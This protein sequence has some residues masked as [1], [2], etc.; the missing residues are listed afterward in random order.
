MV[1][2]AFLSQA[3]ADAT[4]GPSTAAARLSLWGD[5]ALSDPIFLLVLP[6]LGLAFWWGRSRAGRPRARV[7]V[8]AEGLPVSLRQRLG[9]LPTT[10]AFCASV[11]AVLAMAR[12][13]RANALRT[14]ISEGVDI[15]VVVDR[16]GSMQHKDMAAGRTRLDVV[17]DV[18]ADFVARRTGDTAGAADK[19]ALL[20][21][22]R[23]PELLCPF[24]LDADAI[25]GF[26][27]NVQLANSAAEG[28]T[29]IGSALAK[30]VA[31]LTDSEAKSRIVVLLTDGENT[32]FD[33]QPMEAAELAAE[34]GIKVYTIFA[35]KY[36]YEYDPFRGWRAT[37]REPDTREL[38][39]IA[40]LTG[41]SFFRARDGED[42]ERIYAEIERLE[43]TE[44]EERRFEETFDLY[45]HL[46][47]PALLLYALAWFLRATWV[48][49]VL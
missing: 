44:R 4:A 19:V 6:L 15:V 28:G 26:L 27:A 48:R 20:S 32:V 21:F 2:L 7:S 34:E 42:L 16:S 39:A 38:R 24:T 25:Q 17:K 14:D 46:L 3:T 30:A 49:R 33:I 40:E 23:F 41:A 29:A 11:L 37:N 45:P 47:R 1:A 36:Q 13:V 5:L 43:R 35:A 8:L 9:W 22:A 12:P 10:L 18:V 31:V